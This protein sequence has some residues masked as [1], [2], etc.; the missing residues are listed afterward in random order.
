MTETT[1]ED[2]A[3]IERE[4]RRTQDNMSRTVDKIGDQLTIKNVFNA[5]L[6]KA[7][8]NNVDA[9]MLVD[10]A[11]RNPIALGLIAA[12]A[13][14]LVSDKNSKFP[15]L[16]SK[17][18]RTDTDD[19][20]SFDIHHRDYVSHM[21]SVEQHADEDAL[22]YQ[23]RRDTARAN[24]LMV[25][26]DLD[27]DDSSFR[28][29]LD[30]LTEKFRE[31]RHAWAESS[32]RAQVATKEQARAAVGKAQDLYAGNPLVG[33]ILAAAIGAAF[34]SALPATRQEQEKLG[35]LGEKARDAIDESKG[36]VTSRLR[37]KKDELLEKAD[38]AIKPLQPENQRPG[39]DIAQPSGAPFIAGR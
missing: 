7:D 31:K 20:G 8:E 28:Q 29:R 39:G 25:E 9:R 2:P 13:I 21:S 15:S 27:E 18:D 5:L 22:A 14:W 16:P 38:A 23:R 26:R 17:S 35:R 30:G 19:Y 4:I 32:E 36:Q 33:G 3:A 10:G 1:T 12:G 34:G 6:D 11:R 37:D 24:F